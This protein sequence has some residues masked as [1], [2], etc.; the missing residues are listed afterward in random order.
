MDS[1]SFLHKKTEDTYSA[2]YYM[3]LH[4]C[5]IYWLVEPRLLQSLF[6]DV[7]G[8]FGGDEGC[9]MM[10]WVMGWCDVM[11]SIW[12]ENRPWTP[13]PPRPLRTSNDEPRVTLPAKSQK[14]QQGGFHLEVSSPVKF[15]KFFRQHSGF[16]AISHQFHLF[17]VRFWW[18]FVG[19]S[20]NFK[21]MLSY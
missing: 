19:I 4:P 13:L 12:I 10:F 18:K 21:K 15:D 20:R 14:Q 17:S 3:I 8:C 2:W 16:F 1:P 9:K 5:S 7:L 11:W 6:W